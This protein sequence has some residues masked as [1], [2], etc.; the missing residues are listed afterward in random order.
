MIKEYDVVRLKT[1]E[2]AIILEILEEGVAYI[3]EINPADDD[4]S[5]TT[6]IRYTDIIGIVDEVRIVLVADAA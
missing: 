3:V 2:E 6:S 5:E 4:K 1:G